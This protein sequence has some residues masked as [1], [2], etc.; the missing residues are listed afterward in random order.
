MIIRLLNPKYNF[1]N[2]KIAV[3]D[4][5]E[6]PIEPDIPDTPDVPDVPVVPDEPVIP[7]VIPEAYVHFAN[8]YARSSMTAD[9]KTGLARYLYKLET[10][11]IL[12]KVRQLYMPCIAPDWDHCFLNVSRY[13]NENKEEYVKFDLYSNSTL[14]RCFEVCDYGIYRTSD[15]IKWGDCLTSNWA[16]ADVT[17]DNWHI[18][19]FKPAPYDGITGVH[20]GGLNVRSRSGANLDFNFQIGG[21][22]STTSTARGNWSSG[23]VKINGTNVKF[24]NGNAGLFKFVTGWAN[25]THDP[26]CAG[27]SIKNNNL[28]TPSS[29]YDQYLNNNRALV[30]EINEMPLTGQYELPTAALTGTYGWGGYYGGSISMQQNL[31]TS[32][33]SIGQGLS[34]EEVQNYMDA[35]NEFMETLGI[36]NNNWDPNNREA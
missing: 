25:G 29:S 24:N 33:V 18:L 8:T 27:I 4:F 17:F 15:Q 1:I 10:L 2:N 16:D 5:N 7:E 22:A 11:G 9:Q 35:T 6:P 21:A 28:I 19:A 3:I 34:A 23:T 32:I 12:G 20:S 36:K 30:N 13:F 14:G 31:A 26:Y